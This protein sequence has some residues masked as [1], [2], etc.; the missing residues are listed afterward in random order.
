M[1]SDLDFMDVILLYL[2]GLHNQLTNVMERI[3]SWEDNSSLA[4]QEILFSG[5]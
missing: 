1:K 4:S 3:P 5:A 2:N